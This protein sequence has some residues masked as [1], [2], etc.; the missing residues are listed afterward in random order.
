[1]SLAAQVLSQVRG[2]IEEVSTVLHGKDKEQ[3]E[4]MDRIEERLGALESPP[5]SAA[6]RARKNV[7]AQASTAQGTGEAPN[8]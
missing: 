2:L 3:D 1:M 8:A 5:P 4:R 7:K 6:P